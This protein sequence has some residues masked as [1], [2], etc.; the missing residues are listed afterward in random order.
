MGFRE[1]EHTADIALRVWGADRA[2]FFAN[3]AHGMYALIGAEI[4]AAAGGASEVRELTLEAPDIEALLVDWLA[5]L[6]YIAEE[7][8][9]IFGAFR[10]EALSD[11]HLRASL[12]RAAAFEPARL[13]KAVTFHNLE[14]I[15]TARGLE[16]TIVFDV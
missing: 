8:A 12:D 5:E 2:A 13:I 6:L 11:T 9:V 3:A 7:E 1:V 10:F 15:H 14:V 4:G 16:A